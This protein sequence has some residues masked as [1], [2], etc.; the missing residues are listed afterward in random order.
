MQSRSTRRT[1]QVSK[2]EIQLIRSLPCS[3]CG[4][5][6]LM[7]DGENVGCFALCSSSCGWAVVARGVFR[8]ADGWNL[9]LTDTIRQTA[10]FEGAS[11]V[12][13]VCEVDNH[14]C[15]S[16]TG[17][18]RADFMMVRCFHTDANLVTDTFSKSGLGLETDGS[19]CGKE[20]GISFQSL[21][22]G[23]PDAFQREFGS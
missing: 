1:I 8:R 16:F 15:L 6:I 22:A 12:R 11:A 19:F 4:K 7:V 14:D 13:F 21:P 23:W 18:I 17:E 5:P 3:A 9:S 10:G 20:F 2:S